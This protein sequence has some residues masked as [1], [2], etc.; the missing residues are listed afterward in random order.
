MTTDY[1]AT[2][3]D[4]VTLVAFVRNEG[5]VRD[6]YDVVAREYPRQYHLAAAAAICA[7][8][9]SG[10]PVVTVEFKT[11]LSGEVADGDQDVITLTVAVPAGG[12][13]LTAQ[14]SVTLL[15]ATPV[16]RRFA[17]GEQRES[18]PRRSG[19]THVDD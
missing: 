18:V 11:A 9:R 14:T 10:M 5:N 13:N 6:S 2:R 8:C 19:C 7:P 15:I 16:V 1:T 12:S 17:D 3:G 4:E